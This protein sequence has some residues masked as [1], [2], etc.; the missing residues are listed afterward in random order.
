LPKKSFATD[1]SYRTTRD[2]QQELLKGWV[3]KL[4][5]VLF[6][7]ANSFSLDFHAIRHRGDET[8]LENHYQPMRGQAGPSVL[9]FFAMEQKSRVFCYSN[10]NLTRSQQPGEILRFIEFWRNLMGRNPEWLYFDSKLTTYAEL[11]KITQKKNVSFVTIRRRGSSI[12]RR[13]ESLPASRWQSA[14]IDIPRRRHQ[15]IRYVDEHVRLRDYNGEARQIA[16]KGLGR[17]HPTLFLT[18][19]FE[20]SA[21]ELVMNYARRNGVEDALGSSVNFF[22]LDCL[23]SEVRL[24]VDL[25]TVLTVLA[26]G[27]YRWLGSRL[28][29]FEQSKPKALYR[30]FV[31]TSGAVEI[32][33]GGRIVVYLDRR[34]HNPILREAEPDKECPKIPWLQNRHLEFVYN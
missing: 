25:D 19:N 7:E 11:S 22:H 20:T 13:L 30:K 4:S 2:Q 9:T 23:S 24:S 3:K 34:S 14:V 28:H 1:Y 6:P 27:C 29:G 12:L 16:V 8:D 15:Q 33:Q 5:P 10:A 18:N 26:N 17:E 31:E 21:R 32:E